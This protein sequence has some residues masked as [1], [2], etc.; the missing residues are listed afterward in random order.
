MARGREP[1]ESTSERTPLPEVLLDVPLG[2]R[3][4]SGRSRL[5]FQ[6]LHLSSPYLVMLCLQATT[7]FPPGDCPAACQSVQSWIPA[8]LSQHRSPL[9]R[10][11]LRLAVHPGPRVRIGAS[12][13]GKECLEA[14]AILSSGKTVPTAILRAWGFSHQLGGGHAGLCGYQTQSNGTE[15]RR[16]IPVCPVVDGPYTSPARKG[17]PCLLTI[18]SVAERVNVCLGQGSGRLMDGDRPHLLLLDI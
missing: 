1:P 7:H 5:T 3:L 15:T 14:V 12:A 11:G 17:I 10:A 16:C 4:F 18:G 2:G 13:E 6:H 9:F 8:D